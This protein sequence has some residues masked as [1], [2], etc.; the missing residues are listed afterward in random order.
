[1]DELA[2]RPDACAPQRI[3]IAPSPLAAAPTAIIRRGDAAAQHLAVATRE[4]RHRTS[5]H[6][7]II[8]LVS[9]QAPAWLTRRSPLAASSSDAATDVRERRALP[10]LLT[11][12]VSLHAPSWRTSLPAPWGSGARGDGAGL[13][14]QQPTSRRQQ[15]RAS[16]Q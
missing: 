14:D 4:P 10:P 2:P 7:A 16:R 9:V 6:T 11:P 12:L 15:P 13:A 8:P 1:M 3:A 5:L